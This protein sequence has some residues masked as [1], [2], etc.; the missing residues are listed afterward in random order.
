MSDISNNPKSISIPAPDSPTEDKVRFACQVIE[1]A[2]A[3]IRAKTGIGVNVTTHMFP[4]DYAR[5]GRQ[6]LI[7]AAVA[8]GFDRQ[9]WLPENPKGGFYNWDNGQ[10]VSVNITDPDMPHVLTPEMEAALLEDATNG[11]R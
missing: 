8:S 10:G 6:E 5:A 7:R 3:Y 9:E 1:Q 2:A 11:R 4:A